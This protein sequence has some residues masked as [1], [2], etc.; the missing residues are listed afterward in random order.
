MNASSGD[1]RVASELARSI[2]SSRKIANGVWAWAMN[3]RE[4]D[5]GGCARDALIEAG[6]DLEAM[7]RRRG[8]HPLA[9][10]AQEKRS[11][12]V[13]ALMKVMDVDGRNEKGQ[14]A[15]MMAAAGGELGQVEAL[16]DAGAQ[17][18]RV[19]H[20]GLGALEWAAMGLQHGAFD[21]LTKRG[22]RLSKNASSTQMAMSFAA[23]RG[24]KAMVERLDRLGVGYGG[25]CSLYGMMKMAP[26]LDCKSEKTGVKFAS[27][28]ANGSLLHWAA[29]RGWND[30]VVKVL[31]DGE[32]RRFMEANATQEKGFTSFSSEDWQQDLTPLAM[33]ILSGRTE[34]VELL[35][36]RGADM[37]VAMRFHQS[38]TVVEALASCGHLDQA[39]YWLGKA[40]KL[41]Q[42]QVNKI[43]W[44]G[45]GAVVKGLP[46]PSDP[47]WAFNG[48]TIMSRMVGGEGELDALQWLMAHPKADPS[49]E[50]GLLETAASWSVDP[51]TMGYLFAWGLDPMASQ[52]RAQ[53]L[54]ER[55]MR[56]PRHNREMD[57]K[58]VAPMIFESIASHLVE[59]PKGQ[60]AILAAVER[61][62]E[63][64]MDIPAFDLAMF[65]SR[66]RAAVESARQRSELGSIATA[67]WN[68]K[69]MPKRL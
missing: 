67:S 10:V 24:D 53:D 11:D 63:V 16:L 64:G 22:A 50:S 55:A 54:L 57:Y 32:G 45:G 48:E 4:F 46:A 12:W 62:R 52:D 25:V 36:D 59:D 69:A 5:A 2:K 18:N 41:D 30:W 56:N 37:D 65:A 8:V 42:E 7:Y 27:A 21:A 44:R 38:D 28:H 23:L 34:S 40:G 51:A 68:G 17:V 6:V 60:E 47:H 15:L 31:E 1:P 61:S 33:A 39:E 43:W 35:L 58:T 20:A 49:K 66:W 9:R 29:A 3:N 13:F 14:T 19:D 26:W